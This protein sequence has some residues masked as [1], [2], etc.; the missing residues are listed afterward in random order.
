M[1]EVGQ[2]LKKNN[3]YLVKKIKKCNFSYMLRSILIIFMSEV[4]LIYGIV[5][6]VSELSQNLV[7][8][9]K[10][11]FLVTYVYAKIMINLSLEQ[12]C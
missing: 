12:D 6:Q 8:M 5:T 7:S 4:A 11:N 9:N 1:A 2:N 3:F 10:K